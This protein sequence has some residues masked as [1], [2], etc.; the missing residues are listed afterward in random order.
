MVPL[1]FL[2]C[3]SVWPTSRFPNVAVGLTLN[4]V[5]KGSGRLSPNLISTFIAMQQ[6]SINMHCV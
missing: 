5:T 2:S 1:A 3:F 6:N 4:Y